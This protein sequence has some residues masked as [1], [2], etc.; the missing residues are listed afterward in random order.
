MEW[1]PRGILEVRPPDGMAA[2]RIPEVRPPDGMMA[3]R[4]SGC[5]ASGWNEHGYE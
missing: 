3:E 2:D 5:E 4:D 1:W